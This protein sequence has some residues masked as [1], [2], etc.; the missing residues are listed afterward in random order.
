M[1][2]DIEPLIQKMMAEWEI[3]ALAIAVVH[4]GRPSLVKAYGERDLEAKLAAT[5]GTQFAICS[6][7]KSFTATALAILVESGELAWDRPVR[8]YLAGFALI[9][10]LASVQITLRDMLTH[11]SG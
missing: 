11:R 1:Q 4:N 7:T 8:E 3:P 2:G 6:I 9:D 5:T 10:P